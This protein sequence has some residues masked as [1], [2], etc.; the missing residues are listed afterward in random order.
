MET[1]EEFAE[2][3]ISDV[4]AAL[5]G[6][7]TSVGYKLG[8]YNAM[9]HA[10]WLTPKQLANRLKL[11]E[12]YVT[13]WLNG[14]V[15]GRYIEFD[16]RTHC[17]RL[18]DTHIPVLVDS[19]NPDFV[20]PLLDVTSALWHDEDLLIDVFNTGKGI[21]WEAHHYRL[22]YG[23]ESLFR[24]GYQSFLVNSWIAEMEGM[25][26][27][28]SKG[29]I[30]ADVGCGHGAS[31]IVMA[32]AFPA[33]KFYGFDVHQAS[34]AKAKSTAQ[35]AK[36]AANILFEHID[37]TMYPGGDFDLICFID[38][39][40]HMT[41]PIG[42]VRHAARSLKR[43]GRLLLVEPAAGNNLLDNI[44]P[45]S[46]LYYAASTAICS[47]SSLS[48]EADRT[49]GAQAGEQRLTVV[50]KEAGFRGIRKIA[51]TRLNLIMEATLA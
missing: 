25:S 29:A 38:S 39:L 32:E 1:T 48:L 41:D 6:L 49:L 13:E 44:N 24:P 4:S 33:S 16:S 19:S 12:R 3:A 51:Q 47:P 30:V 14:Q 20:V 42:A 11:S 43:E 46:R 18:P 26:E 7:M 8:L 50:L 27:K 10:G 15:A 21:P 40:H 28:L 36:A 35:G 23:T 34:I 37:A 45:V 2:R 22:F 5:S 31:T 9:A 17:F